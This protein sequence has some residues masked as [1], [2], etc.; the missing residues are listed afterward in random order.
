M[1]INS[2]AGFTQPVTTRTSAPETQ[3]LTIIALPKPNSRPKRLKN[4]SQAQTPS[5]TNK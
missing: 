3:P 1:R 4:P 5:I 2:N